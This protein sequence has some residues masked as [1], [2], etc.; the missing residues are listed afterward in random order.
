[1]IETQKEN[2]TFKIV[3]NGKER[4]SK[5]RQHRHLAGHFIRDILLVLHRFVMV[6]IYYR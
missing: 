1:M 3:S 5:Y 2:I 6:G 4:T